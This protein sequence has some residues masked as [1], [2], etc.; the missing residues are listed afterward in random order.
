ME[1]GA[2]PEDN[3]CSPEDLVLGLHLFKP[4][5]IINNKLG[6]AVPCALIPSCSQLS[7]NCILH[8]LLL[9]MEQ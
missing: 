6:Y 5:S 9:E 4:W 7:P 2:K 8:I 3:E 1:V